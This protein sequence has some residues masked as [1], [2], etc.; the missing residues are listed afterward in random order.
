MSCRSGRV[1][2][3]G[4]SDGVVGLW[5]AEDLYAG[6]L[7][8]TS[9]ACSV[10][11]ADSD[12]TVGEDAP[13]TSPRQPK[14][15]CILHP[16]APAYAFISH[17]YSLYNILYTIYMRVSTWLHPPSRLVKR[18]QR[19]SSWEAEAGVSVG[20]SRRR[21]DGGGRAKPGT[22][23]DRELELALREFVAF[24]TVSSDPSLREDCY[25]G[26]KYLC[27]LLVEVLGGPPLGTHHQPHHPCLFP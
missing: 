7:Q 4:S 18:S 8:R 11:S 3:T 23:M 1:V 9:R 6:A 16:S 20:R 12:T 22:G 13:C 24:R 26:A 5:S 27:K 19:P 10:E 21:L 17:I 2:V 25:R 15:T 14:H